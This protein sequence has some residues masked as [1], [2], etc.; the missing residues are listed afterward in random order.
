[1]TPDSV[2]YDSLRVGSRLVVIA[3]PQ[4]EAIFHATLLQ[5]AHEARLSTILVDRK[6]SECAAL[7]ADQLDLAR[8]DAIE[9]VIENAEQYVLDAGVM[10]ECCMRTVITP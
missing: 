1:M 9:R 2:A 8:S 7:I 3:G 4:P 5:Q 6:T 10:V